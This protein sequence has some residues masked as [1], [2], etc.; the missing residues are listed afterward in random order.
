MNLLYGLMA[1]NNDLLL[2]I[3]V[4]ANKLFGRTEHSLGKIIG[5]VITLCL[6]K[7]ISPTYRLLN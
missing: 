5:Y 7:E 4:M 1:R 2:S 6:K 3:A